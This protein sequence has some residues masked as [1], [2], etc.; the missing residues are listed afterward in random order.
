MI[1]DDLARGQVGDG[2]SCVVDEDEYGL[3]G[4]FS[5]DT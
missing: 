5:S 2:A 3:S 1:A 4:A